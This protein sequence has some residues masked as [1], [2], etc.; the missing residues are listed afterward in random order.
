MCDRGTTFQAV[1]S[2][3]AHR[4]SLIPTRSRGEQ[5][6]GRGGQG[7]LGR[8]GSVANGFHA[9]GL[10]FRSC[11]VEGLL[12][13][14]YGMVAA[15]GV[16]RVGERVGPKSAQRAF[17]DDD[18]DIL[19][20]VAGFG[21]PQCPLSL[22]RSPEATCLDD[23]PGGPR[24]RR[25]GTPSAVD[26]GAV[27]EDLEEHP[28]LVA[29]VRPADRDPADQGVGLGDRPVDPGLGAH[30]SRGRRRGVLPA[31]GCRW[32]AQGRLGRSSWGPA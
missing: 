32:R 2:I 15:L 29:V 14:V 18:V 1:P 16:P 26:D 12:E 11:F 24:A 23:R 25:G 20:E 13:L 3:I 21:P 5:R 9:V 27:G 17:E 7:P 8:G 30:P 22:A 31:S 10:S 28:E 6:Q 19:D 4:S